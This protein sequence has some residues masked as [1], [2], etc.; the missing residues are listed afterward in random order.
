MSSYVRARLPAAARTC[1]FRWHRRNGGA[2][3][4]TGAMRLL[5]RHARGGAERLVQRGLWGT[6][7]AGSRR[8]GPVQV[9]RGRRTGPSYAHKQRSNTHTHS[10]TDSLSTHSIQVTV[11]QESRPWS[12]GQRGEQQAGSG[13]DAVRARLAEDVR[14]QGKQRSCGKM[15]HRLHM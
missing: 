2:Q 15:A 13:G 12:G 3:T 11:K 6:R 14:M 5:C 4:L 9:H 8:L 7:S 1:Q 10:L